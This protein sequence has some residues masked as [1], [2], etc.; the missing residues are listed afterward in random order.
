MTTVNKDFRVKHGLVVEGSNA[1]VNGS[2]VL[3]EA[4]TEFLQDTVGG[5]VNGGTQTNITVT[6]NDTNG[7]L[8]FSRTNDVAT[9]NTDALT[10][11][12]TNLYFTE[13]R[14]QDAAASMIVNGT[15][16]NITVAYN[17][18]SNT[19]NL[20]GAVTYTDENARD[21]IGTLITGSTHSGI[22]VAYTD[23][24]ANN[25]TLAFTNTDKGSDQNIFK[26][27]VAG[28][29]TLIADGNNDTLTVSAGN[30][31]SVTGNAT[32]D[33]VEIANTGVLS[34][35]GTTNEVEVSS[36]TG[37][38]TVGLPNNVTIAG[39]IT[40]NGTPTADTHAVTK[41]YVDNVT[42]GLNFHEAVHAATTTNL[43]ATYNNGTA[44]VGA[45]LTADA[46]GALVIDGHTLIV[47][48]RVLVKDQTNQTQN[49]IYDVTDIG[50]GSTP[51]ILTRSSDSDNSPV[52]E[53]AGGDFCFVQ[54]GTVNAG[55]GYIN[56]TDGAIT[57]G[58]TNITYTQFSSGKT[59]VAGNG[60][61][62][63]TPGTLEID[64][65][66]TVDKN[67][68]QTLTNKTIS[69]T[70]NTI[71]VTSSNVTDFT[72]AAQDATATAITTNAT[73]SGVSVAYVDGSN[74]INITNTGVTSVSGTS[75]QVTASASTGSVTLSLP[76]DIATTSSP[77]FAAV[78][79]VNSQSGSATATAGTTETVIDTWSATT[80]SSAK[81]LIQ[82]K[83]NFD[84]EIVELLA[85]VDGNNNVYLTIYGDVISNTSLGS[86]TAD[87]SS[88]SFRLLI[89]AAA[90][91][92]D[93]KVHK[94]LIK[95]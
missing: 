19:L 9:S 54:Q 33:T 36:S 24:G 88:G 31:I 56:N 79:H 72:E 62:E 83:K 87:Y 11:G 80:Y 74:A 3:T 59:V 64:T 63:S 68:A 76:Q 18:S 70:N 39:N 26:N 86:I 45:T 22:S 41:S 42:A 52:G 66:V 12:S 49:G 95:A 77:T 55:Y 40:I 1:T 38:V 16:T 8:N 51:W 4:S 50:S 17:D 58:T 32:S 2:Q 61:I 6:Y 90:T 93:V 53:M 29:T 7:T 89:T 92:T 30:G 82:M 15:H 46:N 91:A 10:E 35:T 67:T 34:L 84:I 44:G 14:A 13:E 73:H 20:T 43:V 48:D 23:D 81:Y 60:L 25:G 71:S 27:V 94:T 28:A 85:T 21:A 65:T 75:N 47:G 69:S 78:S 57:I 5:M 37:T